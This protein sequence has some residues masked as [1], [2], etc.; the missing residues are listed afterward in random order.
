MRIGGKLSRIAPVTLVSAQELI[1]A[2]AGQIPYDHPEL[3]VLDAA[4]VL[5]VQHQLSAEATASM[6][7]PCASQRELARAV[8][9]DGEIDDARAESIAIID[10]WVA[11]QVFHLVDRARLR[12]TET[13]GVVADRLAGVWV[14]AQRH[15]AGHPAR[16]ALAELAEAYDDLVTEVS[17]GRRALPDW[18]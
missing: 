4:R 6:Y 14:R 2:F 9:M 3:A 5:A 7:D 12:H 1:D 17:A 18:S 16:K 10:V 11:R 13:L 15:P 8:R